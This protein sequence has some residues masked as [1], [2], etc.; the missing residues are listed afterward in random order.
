[1]VEVVELIEDGQMME[2]LIDGRL[3]NGM[4]DLREDE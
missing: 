3:V 2:Q 1:M 4:V